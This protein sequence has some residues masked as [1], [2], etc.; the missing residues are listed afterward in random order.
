MMSDL[1]C[2]TG[3]GFLMHMPSFIEDIMKERND[4]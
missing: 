4:G 1:G 3:Q 2:E